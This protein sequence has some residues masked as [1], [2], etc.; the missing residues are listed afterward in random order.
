MKTML[1]IL[2]TVLLPACLPAQY[3]FP[4]I[5]LRTPDG[6]FASSTGIFKPDKPCIVI[7]WKSYDTKC[8]TNLENM[9]T[10]WLSQLQNKGV[11][12]VAIC[13][14]C[15]GTWSH[16]KPIVSGK[17]WEFDIY[18]DIN[19]EFKRALGITDAPYTILFDKNHSIICRHEGYCSGNE[20]VVCEKILKCLSMPEE[21]SGTK[22]I[23]GK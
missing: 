1:L 12:L 21:P 7:F 11:D 16:V 10:A 2:L 17:A 13:V 5:Q 18:I 8:C 22:A 4:D 9:Q 20:D 6:I 14:D 19:G 15:K 23:A 3:H